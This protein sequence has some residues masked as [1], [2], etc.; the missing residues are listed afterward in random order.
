MYFTN[1]SLKT[2]SV[3]LWTHFKSRFNFYY[4]RGS[5]EPLS[6]TWTMLLRLSHR[7][8]YYTMF[9]LDRTLTCQTQFWKGTTKGLVW[10]FDSS[11]LCGFREEDLW[12]CFSRGSN[13]NLGY[14][15]GSCWFRPR[16]VRC[17]FER[18][19]LWPSLVPVDPVVVWRRSLKICFPIGPYV[20]LSSPLAVILDRTRT[21]QT[22]FWK[23]TNQVLL[24][25]CFWFQLTQ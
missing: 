18:G 15:W 13:V 6:F 10:Q 16:P 5:Q 1:I 9:I 3:G 2:G 21:Y 7:P 24:W 19:P 23:G 22:Q 8:L 14:P 20:K 17:N 25:Q 12:M 4:T 11:W